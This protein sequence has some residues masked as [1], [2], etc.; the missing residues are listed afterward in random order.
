MAIAATKRIIHGVQYLYNLPQSSMNKL[1]RGLVVSLSGG[2]C[3]FLCC[4]NASLI[5]NEGA[6]AASIYNTR[7]GSLFSVSSTLPLFFILT[8]RLVPCPGSDARWAPDNYIPAP[9]LSTAPALGMLLHGGRPGQINRSGSEKNAKDLGPGKKCF[10]YYILCVI[11]LL[12]HRMILNSTV[13]QR[14]LFPFPFTTM[15]ICIET[16]S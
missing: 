3:S 16:L 12:F 5:H 15:L 6:S 8:G 7:S 9:T 2:L 4:V 1:T 11:M 13:D 14:A 10:R